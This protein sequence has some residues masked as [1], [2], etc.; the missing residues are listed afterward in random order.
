MLAL[1][2]HSVPP[3]VHKS[4]LT[5]SELDLNDFDDDDDFFLD[6]DKVLQ[7]LDAGHGLATAARFVEM[8]KLTIVVNDLLQLH[9]QRKKRNS[10]L[11]LHEDGV[12]NLL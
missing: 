1:I 12:S 10:I 3:H 7:S 2:A 8:V 5:S 6:V 9:Q 11:N 4:T